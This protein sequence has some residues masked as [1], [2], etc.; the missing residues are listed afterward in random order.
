MWVRTQRIHVVKAVKTAS[1]AKRPVS[2]DTGLLRVRPDRSLLLTSRIQNVP[3]LCI[4][5]L[6]M[7]TR[8]PVSR[9]WNCRTDLA[10]QRHQLAAQRGSGPGRY[11]RQLRQITGKR[12][13]AGGL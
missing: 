10:P 3:D 5:S 6:Q 12:R 8:F 4:G 1:K 2:F 13:I 7:Q 11:P 9:T